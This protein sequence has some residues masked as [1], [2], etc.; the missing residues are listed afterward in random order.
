MNIRILAAFIAIAAIPPALRASEGLY[1]SGA[2]ARAMGMGGAEVADPGT[3]L[4]AMGGN[5]AALSL[6]NSPEADAGLV[7]ASAYGKY[8][9]RT[10]DTGVLSTDFNMGPEGA[11]SMPIPHTPLTVAFG[12]I[13]EIGLDAH[14]NYNDPPGGLGGT[15][16]YGY[17]RDNSEIEDI[18]FAFGLSVQITR[19]LSIGGELGLDYN[20]NL[21]QTPY[22]FQSQPV[23]RGFKT[24][25][26]MTTYGWGAN[27][28]AGILYKPADTVSIGLSYESRTIVKTYGEATA[29]ASAQL[30]ALGPAYA[31]VP[32]EFNYNA[33]VDNTFPQIV[34]GGVAWKFHPR[35]EAAA[36]IDWTGWADAFNTLP[37]KLTNG[38][39][40]A[41]NALVKSNAVEDDVPLD[42]RNAFTYRIG[43]E[44]EIT[45][46]FFLRAG[47]A[48]GRSPVPDGTLTP[49]TAALPQNTLSAGAG[50]RW[51]WLEVDLAYQ[52]DIPD[53][54]NVGASQLLDGEYSGSSV[55]TGIQWLG[56][57]TSA[58]Y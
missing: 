39:N 57:T 11:L 38:S 21:L 3:A 17:Q 56:L 27:G 4:G 5:P 52:W 50:Y 43:I 51:R 20:E 55:R 44:D 42:W 22:V 12:V 53:S 18:K 41:V 37:V 58:R 2:D 33:E 47:Y 14:W 19:Q 34:S 32:R 26:D 36:E 35:W 46:N 25:L 31:S 13:P 30:N 45:D 1:G 16:S 40:P 29:D 54:R 15:A 49:M 8:T 48:F 28:T 9:S 23:L 7:G 6:F 10:G 24:L